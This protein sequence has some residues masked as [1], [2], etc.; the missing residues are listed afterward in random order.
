M[1]SREISKF[2]TQIHDP[3]LEPETFPG[4]NG[5]CIHFGL[6]RTKASFFTLCRVLPAVGHRADHSIYCLNPSIFEGEKKGFSQTYNNRYKQGNWV[7]LMKLGL[8]VFHHRW[9]CGIRAYFF[10]KLFFKFCLGKERG[11]CQCRAARLWIWSC[12]RLCHTPCVKF[13][14]TWWLSW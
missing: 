6:T 4:W 10:S 8:V 11:F 9:W 5:E 13:G 3:S 12:L 2:F 7:I 14:L 1:V